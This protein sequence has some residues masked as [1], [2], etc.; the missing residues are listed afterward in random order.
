[1]AR[2]RT[3]NSAFILSVILCLGLSVASI[4]VG[5]AAIIGAFLAGLALA[6]YSDHWKLQEN[7]HPIYE[8]LTP[9]FFVLLGAQ[10]DL[11]RFSTPGLLPMIAIISLLAIVSKMIGCGLG[12]MRLGAKDALRIGVGMVP[13]GEVGF[14]VAAVGLS[15]HTIS[16]AI[17]AVVLLMCIITTLFA[18]PAAEPGAVRKNRAKGRTK[19]TRPPS[20]YG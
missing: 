14:I 3:Q 8:F 2:L 7:A 5:M 16:D 18:P 11:K 10:V 9:F 17:Y 6:E 19:S 12:A 1:M 20:N 13:R 4:Y 15:L